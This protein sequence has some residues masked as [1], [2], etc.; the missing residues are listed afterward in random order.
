MVPV[1][2]LLPVYNGEKYLAETL[3]SI[4]NQTFQDFETLIINDGSTDGTQKIIDEFSKRD[5]NI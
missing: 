3:Q 2:F 4:S 1:T 5:G